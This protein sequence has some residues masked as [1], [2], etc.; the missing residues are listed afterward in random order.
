MSPVELCRKLEPSPDICLN[1]SALVA[2]HKATSGY[3]KILSWEDK[4]VGVGLTEQ[5]ER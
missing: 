5:R 4:E 1:Y 2:S 3:E